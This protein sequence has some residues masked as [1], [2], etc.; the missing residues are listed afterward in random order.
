MKVM[1][2]ESKLKNP[3]KDNYDLKEKKISATI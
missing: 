1:E 3:K 2:V